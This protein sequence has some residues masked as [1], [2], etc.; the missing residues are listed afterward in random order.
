MEDSKEGGEDVG[1]G[2][3]VFDEDEGHEGDGEVDEEV[4]KEG[5]L[6]Q[7]ED[8]EHERVDHEVAGEEQRK[9]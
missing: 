4:G 1:E 6:A 5:V 2:V 9:R 7:E 3:L 8:E